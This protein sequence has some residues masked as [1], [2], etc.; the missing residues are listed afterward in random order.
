[1]YLQR[2]VDLTLDGLEDQLVDQ[3]VDPLDELGHGILQQRLE[4]LSIEGRERRVAR[5]RCRDVR[6]GDAVM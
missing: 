6:R 4:D 3:A 5:R 2:G 1:M